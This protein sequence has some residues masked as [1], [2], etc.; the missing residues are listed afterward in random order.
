[1][2]KFK[3]VDVQLGV[4]IPGSKLTPIRK[5]KSKNRHHT[6]ECL[7]ECGRLHPGA[8]ATKLTDLSTWQCTFCRA[9]EAQKTKNRGAGSPSPVKS[10]KEGILSVLNQ[11]EADVR[12]ES[13]QENELQETR[14]RKELARKLLAG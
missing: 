8:R 5:V 6:Y 12:L 3:P 11:F 14:Q 10:T 2:F 7:C 13:Q 9:A 4:R 1:M